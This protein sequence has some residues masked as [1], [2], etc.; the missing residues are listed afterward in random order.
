MCVL[1]SNWTL[2]SLSLSY[3]MLM[4]HMPLEILA[5]DSCPYYCI[6]LESLLYLFVFFPLLCCF[7]ILPSLLLWPFL[8][9]P[10]P[11]FACCFWPTES[12]FSHWNVKGHGLS[13]EI[14]LEPDMKPPNKNTPC[15]KSFSSETTYSHVYECKLFEKVTRFVYNSDE[16]WY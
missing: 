16:P 9:P 1:S 7:P 6:L 14:S 12:F 11:S 4:F 13:V 15:F 8:P 10:L 3:L 5:V 2:F